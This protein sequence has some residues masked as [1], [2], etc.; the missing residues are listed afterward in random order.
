MHGVNDL[1]AVLGLD[2]HATDH[3]IAS[4]YRSLL[5]QYHPDTASSPVS[6]VQQ[7]H[8]LELLV[9]IMDAYAVL[10][11][12]KRRERHDRDRVR[13]ARPGPK[14]T[15]HSAH[16]GSVAHDGV[17]LKISPLLWEKRPGGDP[18]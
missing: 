11:N 14:V 16:L 6:A 3:E 17:S 15:F 12:H 8:E 1:Y 13:N 10:S 5:R 4:A 7:A 18:R 2:S 9:D